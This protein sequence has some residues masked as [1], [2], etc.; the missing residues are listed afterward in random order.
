MSLGS[1][2]QWQAALFDIAPF[3]DTALP[4]LPKSVTITTIIGVIL[5]CQASHHSLY[6]LLL[7]VKLTTNVACSMIIRKEL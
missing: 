4:D 2:L 3:V 6:T 7:D 1:L 5:F